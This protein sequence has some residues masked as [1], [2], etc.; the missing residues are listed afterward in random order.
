MS[1]FLTPGRSLVSS[2]ENV[3]LFIKAA[4][5][6]HVED[7]ET[8][9]IQELMVGNQP[10]AIA[11]NKNTKFHQDESVVYLASDQRVGVQSDQS[12]A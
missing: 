7:R 12:A 6:D 1:S 3:S 10:D 4:E 2:T 9:N 5:E 8:R 11:R